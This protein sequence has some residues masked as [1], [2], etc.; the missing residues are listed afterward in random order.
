[1]VF[2]SLNL[3]VRSRGP[4]EFWR[5]RKIFAIAAHFIGRRRNCYSLAIRGVHRSLMFATKGRK[6]KKEDMR[7]LWLT[8]CN[9][10]LTEHDMEQKTFTEALTRCNILLNYKTLADLACW[11]PRTFKSLVA[12]AGARAQQDGLKS[13]NKILESTTTISDG[14][15]E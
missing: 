9:A 6:L 5:K 4:D 15:I 8:R 10:A 3:L 13:R 2:L 12:I 11:E 1:M 14:L 7:E